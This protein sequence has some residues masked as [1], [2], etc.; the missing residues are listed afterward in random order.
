M[1]PNTRDEQYFDDKDFDHSYIPPPPPPPQTGH[2]F[3][4][5]NSQA[6]NSSSY[7][8]P[9]W[10]RFNNHLMPPIMPLV[11]NHSKISIETDI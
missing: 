9:E 6:V 8:S 2:R 11:R 4:N 3:Y 7:Q 1:T 5:D 10:K